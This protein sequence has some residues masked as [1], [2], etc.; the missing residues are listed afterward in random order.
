MTDNGISPAQNNVAT[1]VHQGFVLNRLQELLFNP[2]IN[3]K[4]MHSEKYITFHVKH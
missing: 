3:E 1:G 4:M 2:G